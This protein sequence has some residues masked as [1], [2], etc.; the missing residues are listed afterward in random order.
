MR[1]PWPGYTSGYR[2]DQ[3]LR[4]TRDHAQN[5]AL[6]ARRTKQFASVIPPKM[7]EISHFDDDCYGM[8]PM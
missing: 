5:D 4:M 3:V 6:A 8:M 2:N 1:M 7:P